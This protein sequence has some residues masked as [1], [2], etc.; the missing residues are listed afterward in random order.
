MSLHHSEFIPLLTTPGW[1]RP[2][3]GGGAASPGPGSRFHGL[4]SPIACALFSELVG[5]IPSVSTEWEAGKFGEKGDLCLRLPSK[6]EDQNKV[7]GWVMRHG[8]VDRAVTEP[9][10]PLSD[11][12]QRTAEPFFQSLCAWQFS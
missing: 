10:Q 12:V 2:D 6:R 8:G 11:G 1:S 3:A 4:G 9:L 7:G 5:E